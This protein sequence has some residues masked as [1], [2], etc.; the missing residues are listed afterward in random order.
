MKY[1]G[2]GAMEFDATYLPQNKKPMFTIGNSIDTVSFMF[3][4]P[5]D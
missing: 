1:G 2:Q 3:L 5:F 4:E